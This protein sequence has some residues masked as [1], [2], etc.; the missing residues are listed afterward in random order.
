[1]SDTPLLISPFGV[2]ERYLDSTPENCRS[3][4]AHYQLSHPSP[5]LATYLP[6]DECCTVGECCRAG[7]IRSEPYPFVGSGS[8][9]LKIRKTSAMRFVPSCPIFFVDYI[10]I[11]L[12]KLKMLL[13]SLSAVLFT[14]IKFI[15]FTY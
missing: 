5:Y 14:A 2:F 9:L 3:K 7:R 10:N 6:A 8:D 1:M 13:K 11:S 15:T 4:Q 12:E